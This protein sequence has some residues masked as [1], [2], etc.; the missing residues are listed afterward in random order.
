MSYN[1]VTEDGLELMLEWIMVGTC[2]VV[3]VKTASVA[4]ACV[5]VPP[6]DIP[7]T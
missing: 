1:R 2:A 3:P 6:L 7:Q 4:G 5:K